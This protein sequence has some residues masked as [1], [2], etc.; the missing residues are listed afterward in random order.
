MRS[1]G[2]GLWVD[3]YP[4]LSGF[5]NSLDPSDT[6]DLALADGAIRQLARMIGTFD[7]YTVNSYL[8]DTESE[9]TWHVLEVEMEVADESETV[10]FAFLLIDDVFVLGDVD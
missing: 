5:A 4:A 3:R 6:S 7:S 2:W 1:S 8:T 10:M 9:G